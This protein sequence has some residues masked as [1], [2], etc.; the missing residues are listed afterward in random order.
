MSD[1][2]FRNIRVSVWQ[3][4]GLLGLIAAFT[5]MGTLRLNDCDLF[6]P[7]SPRYVLYSQSIVDLGEYRATDLP[8]SPV[9]TWRPPGL[10]MLLAP[11]M[12]LRP[13]DVVA[14]KVVVLLTGA[15][16]LW[17]VFQFA[18]LHCSGW[19]ALCVTA[20]VASSPSFFVMSTEVLTEVPYAVGVMIVLTILSRSTMTETADPSQQKRYWR[21][22]MMVIA[23][24]ALAFTPWLRTAGIA[25]VA[26]AALWVVSS[27]AR[28][29][30][31]PTVAGA[32]I[33]FLA[34]AWRNKQAGGENYIGSTMTRLADK[35]LVPFIHSGLETVWQYVRAIP[36]LLLPGFL[37][38]RAWYS[39]VL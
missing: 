30:W 33:A 3:R 25:L 39:P 11:M 27:R 2:T 1:D 12:A 16:L 10:S 5:M 6:N 38:D 15:L 17:V 21:M 18:V 34:L 36:G 9:Y 23:T 29:Q 22:A 7:D 14:A 8:G 35:G 4:I 32:V 13:Y 31:I 20:L 19:E 26:A 28:Y 24:I 37:T